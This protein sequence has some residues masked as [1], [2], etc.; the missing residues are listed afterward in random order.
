MW[1]FKN[2]NTA[3]L[4]DSKAGTWRAVH[5]DSEKQR[6]GWPSWRTGRKTLFSFQH[7]F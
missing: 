1:V 7:V 6:F 2:S 4:V 3:Y 5:F